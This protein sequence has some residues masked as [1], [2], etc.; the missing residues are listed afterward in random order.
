MF[1]LISQ[2]CLMHSQKSKLSLAAKIHVCLKFL[3]GVIKMVATEN[4]YQS[5]L[6]Y[7]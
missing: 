5:D 6:H 4:I 7:D 2:L 3:T 1:L